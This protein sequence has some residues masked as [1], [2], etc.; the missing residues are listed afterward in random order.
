M[1]VLLMIIFVGFLNHFREMYFNPAPRSLT[2]PS[3]ISRWCVAP[4]WLA[5]APLFVFGVWWPGAL[6]GHFTSIGRL[7]AVVHP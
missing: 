3:A 1:I 7:L 6:W 4:M 2:Q 5:L